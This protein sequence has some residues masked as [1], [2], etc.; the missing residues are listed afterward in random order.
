MAIVRARRNVS[1]FTLIYLIIG[2]VVAWQKSYITLTLVKQVL[3]A[4]LAVLLW[5]LVLLGVNLTIH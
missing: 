2:F 5:F 3:S 1:L 4:I